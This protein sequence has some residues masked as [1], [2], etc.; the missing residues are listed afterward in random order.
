METPKSITVITSQECCTD[1]EKTQQ[2]VMKIRGFKGITQQQEHL[3]DTKRAIY[4]NSAS[5]GTNQSG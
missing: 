5:L 3:T 2:N 1:L 4:S